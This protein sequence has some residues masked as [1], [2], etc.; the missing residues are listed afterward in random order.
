PLLGHPT[1]APAALLAQSNEDLIESAYRLL[2]ADAMPF[3]RNARIQLEHGGNDDS[4]EHYESVAYWYG[5]DGACLDPT[6][7]LDVGDPS[8]ESAHGYD[9]PTASA[10]ETLESRYDLG[11]DHVGAVE[12][13]PTVSEDGRHMTGTTELRMRIRPDNFGVLL[14][15]RLDYALPDQR[16]E[17]WVAE[18]RAGASFERAGTWYLAGSNRCVYSNPP[19]ELDPPDPIVQTSNRR[20]REDEL[21]IRSELTRGRSALRIRIVW[22]K[23]EQPITPDAELPALGWSELAYAAYAWVLPADAP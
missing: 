1:G 12:V 16:A 11:P 14:R 9:S 15:R 17:V 21:S 7:T 23:V 2:I 8:D 18:D 4:T 20:L 5:S 13:F 3:G 22:Q 19:G 10:V 6:D